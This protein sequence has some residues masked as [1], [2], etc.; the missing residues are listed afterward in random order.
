MNEQQWISNFDGQ[1]EARERLAAVRGR[2]EAPQMTM[3]E[4]SAMGVAEGESFRQ[5]F[6][7]VGSDFIMARITS[8]RDGSTTV[9]VDLTIPRFQLI[10]EY[11]EIRTHL[12]LLLCEEHGIMDWNE[13]G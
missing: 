11:R 6:A 5:V 7:T 10:R 13:Q 8:G 3:D 2:L 12:G 9:N 1:C 4:I